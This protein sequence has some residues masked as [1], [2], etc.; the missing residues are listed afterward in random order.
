MLPCQFPVAG[1]EIDAITTDGPIRP[2]YLLLN[3]LCDADGDSREGE[4]GLDNNQGGS[5]LKS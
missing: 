2:G 5:A 1:V 3:F 4:V